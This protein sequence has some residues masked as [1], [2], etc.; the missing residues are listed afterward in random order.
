[1]W[2]NFIPLLQLEEGCPTGGVVG[3]RKIP[4]SYLLIGILLFYLPP[5]PTG[6]P[7]PTEEENL[8]YFRVT[9]LAAKLSFIIIHH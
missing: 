9:I 3:E 6:T 5:P 7:P 4:L 1:M 2:S 8:R